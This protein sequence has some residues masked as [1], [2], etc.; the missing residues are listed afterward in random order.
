MISDPIAVFLAAGAHHRPPPA[1]PATKDRTPAK[2]P[3]IPWHEMGNA[4]RQLESGPAHES[5]APWIT[6]ACEISGYT[7][8]QLRRCARML[9]LLEAWHRAGKIDAPEVYHRLPIAS[10]DVISRIFKIS[11]QHAIETLN[12]L[13]KRPRTSREILKFYDRLKADHKPARPMSGKNAAHTFKADV[14]DALRSLNRRGRS[15]EQQSNLAV[16]SPP[17]NL[18][19]VD[20]DAIVTHR[21]RSQRLVHHA[22][23]AV[24]RVTQVRAGREYALREKIAFAATFFSSC[25]TVF[26]SIDAAT[27]FIADLDRVGHLRNVGVLILTDG[28][29]KLARRPHGGP[30]PDRRAQLAWEP[31]WRRAKRY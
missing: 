20:P 4:L 8:V 1:E 28:V 19:D 30:I 14:I 7:P 12:G 26:S 9:D 18:P 2:P 5:G 22:I 3:A 23:Y 27:K 29:L 10:L 21:T 13:L 11:E 31:N 25:S 6:I 17:Q 24:A 16:Q 15:A